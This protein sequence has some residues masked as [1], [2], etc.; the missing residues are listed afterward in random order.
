MKKLISLALA[1]CITCALCL[2]GVSAA[3]I[4]RNIIYQAAYGQPTVDGKMDEIYLLSDE[5]YAENV[6]FISSAS[7]KEGQAATAKYRLV[8][9]QNSLYI[10][11]EVSDPTRS[12]PGAPSASATKMDNVDIYILCDP[13]FSIEKSYPDRSLEY[14]GQF[15]YNPNCT[16]DEEPTRKSSWGGLTVIN[17]LFGSYEYVGG[18]V[19]DKSGDYYFE[20]KIDFNESYQNTLRANI[21]SGADTRLGF[22]LQV[23]DVMDNDAAR[24]A[25]T[26]SNNATSGLSKDLKNCGVVSLNVQAGAE[27]ITE[28]TTPVETTTA[29]PAETTPAPDDTTTAAPVTTPADTTTAAPTTAPATTTTASSATTSADDSSSGCGSSIGS[30]ALALLAAITAAGVTLVKKK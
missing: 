18:Y 26:F 8:W 23:N 2:I 13:E 28:D 25:Y 12:D 21:A 19:N 1:L 9:N 11:C 10:W 6:V 4:D 22:S 3:D 15:R 24:D 16:I 17:Q 20:M 5:M 30:A 27:L 29:E 7:V 14:S